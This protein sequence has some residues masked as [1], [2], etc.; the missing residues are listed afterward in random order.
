M[1]IN[2]GMLVGYAG[3]VVLVSEIHREFKV[4]QLN[5]NEYYIVISWSCEY[6]GFKR[7]HSFIYFSYYELIV[8]AFSFV[9]F[10]RTFSSVLPSQQWSAGFMLVFQWPIW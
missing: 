9:G 10:N 7:G 2:K 6:A 4:L 5:V 3:F 1:A 8:Y